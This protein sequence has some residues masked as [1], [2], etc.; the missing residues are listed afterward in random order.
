MNDLLE[1]RKQDIERIRQAGL[2]LY[3]ERF[4][5]SYPNIDDIPHQL[6]QDLRVA[7]RVTALRGFGKLIFVKLSDVTGRIQAAISKAE[8]GDEAFKLFK[9]AVKVGDFVGV[10]GKTF[11]TRT[12]EFTVKAENF[13]I[14]GLALRELPEKWH[15]LRD[16]ETRYRQRYLDII[17]N[18]Q[19]R[20][21][22]LKRCKL[23]S[24]MRTIFEREGFFEIETPVLNVTQ[25]GA[26]AK[27]FVTHHNA[28]DIDVFLRIAPETY[29]KRA[30]AAGFNRTFEF[31]KCFR[32]EGISAEHLQEFTMLEYYAAYWNYRDNMRFTQ[33]LLQESLR[34]TFGSL[35]F[36]LPSQG[37]GREGE[38]VKLDFSGDWPAVD[39][40]DVIQEHSGVDVRRYD[41]AQELAAA[42]S[43]AGVRLDEDDVE[44]NNLGRIIDG[45]YKR[46]ARPM[47]VQPTFLTGHPLQISPLARSNDQDAAI[48]DR[49]Q[50][51]VD[52][53]ELVNAYS[54]LVDP[55]EQRRRLTEQA[56]LKSG[57]DDEAMDLDEDY[58]LC[59]EHGMP[60][61]SGTGIGI[62]RLLKRVAGLTNIKD[63]LLFPLMRKEAHE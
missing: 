60:P 51:V 22:M 39:F 46:T 26:L 45:L 23:I 4:E 61:I 3:P 24:S 37:E 5:T 9:K 42:A 2:P 58:L 1:S 14:L 48:V 50:L 38:T 52:G 59:M 6:D 55:L 56:A 19:T 21:T 47:L 31:A 29:L 15:G 54:E 7:G 27:P 53:A 16:V 17:S 49:F 28:L 35:Q 10:S 12:E 11:L 34:E 18:E 40:R 41:S 62:D 8:V 25:S 63:A 30:T 43:R 32:N 57:G 33:R 20:L 13:Q 44:S 36:E